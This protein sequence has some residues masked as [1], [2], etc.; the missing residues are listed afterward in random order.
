MWSIKRVLWLLII[1]IIIV[2]NSFI[3]RCRFDSW[4]GSTF[5]GVFHLFLLL[6]SVI[7]VVMPLGSCV[8]LSRCEFFFFFF[9][10]LLF[11]RIIRIY[12]HCKLKTNS[13]YPNNQHKTEV[14]LHCFLYPWWFVL[15][16]VLFSSFALIYWPIMVFKIEWKKNVFS[17]DQVPKRRR[18]RRNKLCAKNMHLPNLWRMKFEY[19]LLILS[20]RVEIQNWNRNHLDMRRYFGFLGHTMMIQASVLAHASPKKKK[21]FCILAPTSNPQCTMYKVI[22]IGKISYDFIALKYAILFIIIIHTH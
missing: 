10:C 14:R 18:R 20:C 7:F 3:F 1:I 21:H 5:C 17:L 12:I 22:P 15:L 6:W 13:I 8:I 16:F 9:L 11:L 4:F 19:N 2:S